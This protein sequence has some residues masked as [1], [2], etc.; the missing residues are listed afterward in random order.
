MA[1]TRV[2]MNR[3]QTALNIKEYMSGPNFYN[4]KVA[5]HL[6][7][8]ES[9][10]DFDVDL[11]NALKY[12][13]TDGPEIKLDAGSI[14]RDKCFC[15]RMKGKTRR[16]QA[17]VID[18]IIYEMRGGYMIANKYESDDLMLKLSSALVREDMVTFK[19]VGFVRKDPNETER[20]LEEMR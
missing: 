4:L 16:H 13:F 12:F 17:F 3:F 18:G 8:T 14:H 2:R 20:L 19:T 7:D 11:V 15:V 9:T 10:G 5:I 1:I 6:G